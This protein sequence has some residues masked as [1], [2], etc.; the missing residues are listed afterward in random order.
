MLLPRD[1]LNPVR[2]EAPLTCSEPDPARA[3]L[4]GIAWMSL[5]ALPPYHPMSSG[6]IR[7]PDGE[8]YDEVD[9]KHKLL[10][11][12]LHLK[13]LDGVVLERPENFAWLT[14]G[15]DNARRGT[16]ET[17][18]ALFI[19]RDARVVLCNAVDS[20]QLFDRE[21]PGLGFQVK[22]R[23]WTEPREVLISDLCRGR[24]VASDTGVLGTTNVSAELA[25]F[26]RTINEFEA[27][28]LRTLGR[29]VAHAIEATARSLTRGTTEAEVAGEIA[30]RLIKHE[31]TPVR[32]QVMA[33]GQ[34]AR[35]RHWSYGMDKIERHCVISVVGRQFGLHAGC[36]RTVSFGKP[37]ADMADTHQ[38]ASLLQAT[39]LYFSHAGWE[40]AE[41][42][43]R[44]QR[45]YEKFGVADEWRLADQAEALGYDLCGMMV[46]PEQTQKF[47][48]G[49]VIHWHPSVRFASTG[50]TL[51]VHEDRTEL[52]TPFEHWP[53]L[54]VQIK[55]ITIDRP[56][57]L[58]R[59]AKESEW[60][61]E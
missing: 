45:I 38:V 5:T 10:A 19:S 24:N 27:K 1:S 37:P 2:S 35:Y 46:T 29:W 33:D 55:G 4:P 41:T 42:W 51:L 52:V 16:A 49:Q 54:K 6:E 48:P 25:D 26:R 59:D 15:G 18:A 31:I 58:N 21:L 3:P 13:Q 22:E 32:I 44:L 60:C 30:H 23:E 40:V 57:I 7:L 47:S 9:R 8:R 56:A 43:K 50:D 53:T 36:T 28:R 14:T 11:E 12:Y 61:L 39:G 34:G 17:T 20:G